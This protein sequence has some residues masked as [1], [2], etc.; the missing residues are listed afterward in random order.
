MKFSLR[1]FMLASLLFSFMLVLHYHLCLGNLECDA[2]QITNPEESAEFNQLCNAYV[3][4]IIGIHAVMFITRVALLQA[5]FYKFLNGNQH[6]GQ[7]SFLRSAL[8]GSH[9]KK[10]L[11]LFCECCLWSELVLCL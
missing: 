1:A 9:Q 2:A 11:L 10:S 8:F 3:C 4:Q 7:N 5:H 6:L